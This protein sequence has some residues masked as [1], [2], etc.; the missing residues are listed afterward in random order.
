MKC[1]IED[2]NKVMKIF[3]RVMFNESQLREFVS[4]CNDVNCKDDLGRTMLHYAVLNENLDAVKV[5]LDAN[6]SVNEVD[7]DLRTPMH[8]LAVIGN[9]DITRYILQ[10]A[11]VS[12]RED[13][14]GQT[15]LCLAELKDNFGVVD[16]ITMSDV[17]VVS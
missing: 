14:Y 10:H 1:V 4:Y 11:S 6:A 13:L 2:A 5:L 7:N 3:L 9:L 17:N 16:M 15:P 12:C 8:Y